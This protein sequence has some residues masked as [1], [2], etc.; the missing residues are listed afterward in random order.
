MGSM[1]IAPARYRLPRLIARCVHTA[2]D[3]RKPPSVR[4]SK[5]S[6][7]MSMASLSDSMR[8]CMLTDRLDR[9]PEMAISSGGMRTAGVVKPAGS[10]ARQ[11]RGAGV[12]RKEKKVSQ[13]LRINEG[14]WSI[15]ENAKWNSCRQGLKANTIP[16][17]REG[18]APSLVS[19]DTAMGPTTTAAGRGEGAA[20]N[21]N[22]AGSGGDGWSLRRGHSPRQ[23]KLA[24]EITQGP[25]FGCK[26]AVAT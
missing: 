20:A 2:V 14:R 24:R 22:G 17:P 10:A 11:T 3:F 7:S 1:V 13:G 16:V 21:H 15:P 26:A 8:P 19:T 6:V 9:E 5:K 4:P 25:R 12:E 18:A 23:N